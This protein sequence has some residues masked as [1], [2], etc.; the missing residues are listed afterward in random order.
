MPSDSSLTPT[1]L[2]WLHRLEDVLLVSTVL[3]LLLLA[4]Y[5]VIAR[6]FFGTGLVWG[7]GLVRVLVFWVTV[8]G[9]MMAARRNEHI[10]IDLL[11]RFVKPQTNRLFQRLANAFTC[12]MCALL[13]WY[14]YQFVLFE[15]QDGTLAFASV[16]AWVC[17]S[18]LPVGAAVLTLRYGLRTVW[19]P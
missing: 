7:D 13:A 19:L 18:V 3:G 15:Y 4:A 8:V 1:P 10:R 11:S 9:A 6:N 2:R 12:I 16:P 14:S 5:Q 17:E